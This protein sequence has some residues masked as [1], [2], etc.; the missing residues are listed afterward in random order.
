MDH[1]SETE[2]PFGIHDMQF[3]LQKVEISKFLQIFNL[4]TT[5]GSHKWIGRRFVSGRGLSTLQHSSKLREKYFLPLPLTD[6]SDLL[7]WGYLKIRVFGSKPWFSEESHP[8]HA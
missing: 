2:N 4:T 7:L 3:E 6:V 1:I 5:V 8:V